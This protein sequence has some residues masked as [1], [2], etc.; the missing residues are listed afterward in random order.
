MRPQ[1]KPLCSAPRSQLPAVVV[2]LPLQTPS[3]YSATPTPPPP[4]PPSASANPYG[5]WIGY[6]LPL[7]YYFAYYP[8]IVMAPPPSMP[9]TPS[10]KFRKAKGTTIF[11]QIGRKSPMAALDTIWRKWL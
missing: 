2:P 7:Y 8:V 1:G 4:S 10:P 11:W 5:S 3:S 9:I 6:P